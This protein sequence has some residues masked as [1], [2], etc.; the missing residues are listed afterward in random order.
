[1]AATIFNEGKKRLFNGGVDLDASD[2]RV[3]LVKDTYVVDPDQSAL[4][5]GTSSDIASHEVTASGYARQTLANKVVSV[6]LTNNFSYFDAD[7]VT[8]PSMA[9]G[10]SIGGVVL[11]LHTGSDATAVPLVFYPKSP[12]Q[13]TAGSA[14]SVQ[15]PTPA[16]GAL[17]KGV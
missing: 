2:L 9:V 13:P 6:D 15:W 5:D 4:D 11:F 3:L 14:L 1:M 7:D 8:F 17:L 10:Q 12:A 16:N